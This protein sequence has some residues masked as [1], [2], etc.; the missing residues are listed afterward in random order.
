MYNNLPNFIRQV[1]F[2]QMFEYLGLSEVYEFLRVNL[3]DTHTI[4]SVGLVFCILV[5]FG[6]KFDSIWLKIFSIGGLFFIL[7][8]IYI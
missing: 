5:F 1:N 4:I 8:F 2:K 3:M 6:I 7:F